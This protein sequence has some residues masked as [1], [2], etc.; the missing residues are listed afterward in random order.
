MIQNISAR[1]GQILKPAACVTKQMRGGSITTLIA[2]M[3]L[4]SAAASLHACK[5]VSCIVYVPREA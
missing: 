5:E 4:R 3:A 1:Y 2:L